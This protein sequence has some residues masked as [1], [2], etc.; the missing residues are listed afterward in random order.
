MFSSC[1]CPPPWAMEE[2][3]DI[4]NRWM[5]ENA[6]KKDWRNQMSTT[7]FDKCFD[8]WLCSFT[9]LPPSTFQLNLV[10][11]VFLAHILNMRLWAN[12]PP[13]ENM[14]LINKMYCQI[15][16]RFQPYFWRKKSLTH[17]FRF[18][19]LPAL[20]NYHHQL[21]NQTWRLQFFLHKLLNMRI[22]KSQL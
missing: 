22:L 17:G 13:K 14:Q 16:R 18:S 5:V 12:P 10:C 6:G 20:P 19:K 7:R 3:S 8:T 15:F 9:K 4:N 2:H 11:S 21:P 1:Q